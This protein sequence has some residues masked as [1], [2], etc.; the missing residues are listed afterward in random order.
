MTPFEQVKLD[1]E[2]RKR[3]KKESR[4]CYPDSIFINQDLLMG[5]A[6]DNGV[7]STQVF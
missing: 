6:S 4:L 1:Y 5:F 3:K 7:K 2:Q